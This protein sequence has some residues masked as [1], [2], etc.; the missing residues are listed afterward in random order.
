LTSLTCQAAQPLDYPGLG[1]YTYWMGR[2]V[3]LCL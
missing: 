3:P 1:R 2:S